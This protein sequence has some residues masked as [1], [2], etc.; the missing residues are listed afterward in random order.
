V[1]LGLDRAAAHVVLL[2]IRLVARA[3]GRPA[4]EGRTKRRLERRESRLALGAGII[5][6]RATRIYSPPGKRKRPRNRQK[7]K[8]RL[9]LWLKIGNSLH[10]RQPSRRRLN[11]RLQLTNHLLALRRTRHDL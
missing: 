8:K 7:M 9:C 5:G 2:A 4:L 3:L 1:V 6:L 11:G 10:R